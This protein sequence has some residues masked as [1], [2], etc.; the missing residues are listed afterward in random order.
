MEDIYEWGLQV[1]RA[2]Q[3]IRCA[4]LDV[5]GKFIHVVFNSPIYIVILLFYAFCVDYRKARKMGFSLLFTQ[6][7]VT[8]I[9]NRLCVPRPY[10]RDPSVGLAT[11]SSWSTPSGH[12]AGAAAVFPVMGVVEKKWKRW[13][14]IVVAAVVPLFIGV[15]RCYVGVHYPTDV[16][17]GLCLGYMVALFVVLFLDQ[18]DVKLSGLRTSYR[19]L[20][21]AL[22]TYLL[23][24]LD[25]VDSSMTGGFFGLE[26]G[27]ILLEKQGG[28]DASKG[29]IKQKVLRFLLGAAITLVPYLL[30]KLFFPS[31]GELRALFRFIRYLVTC[32]MALYV[33]PL[34][35]IKLGLGESA[36]ASSVPEGAAE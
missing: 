19:I 31:E 23:L 6:A 30:M 21:A 7:L 29:T 2:I 4:P 1:I 35:F 5:L 22:V 14:R 20:I 13:V 11:E 15:S 8:G 28:F 9:K 36:K 26:L 33:S 17:S 18:I 25:N 32:F 27:C 34:V 24:L 12:S 3:T 10:T 16:L